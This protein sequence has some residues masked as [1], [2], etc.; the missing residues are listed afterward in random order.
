MAD[1]RK[2]TTQLLAD[3][4]A[5]VKTNMQARELKTLLDAIVV[6]QKA[7][8]YYETITDFTGG[9]TT[10]LDSIPTIGKTA[11]IRIAVTINAFPYNYQL[12]SGTIA[13]Y[14]EAA[15][16]FITP[17]DYNADTNAKVWVCMDNLIPMKV[18]ISADRT[19]LLK[20]PLEILDAL[21]ENNAVF[22][23][24]GTG[25]N[26]FNTAAFAAAADNV[27][28]LYYEE[29]ASNLMEFNASFIEAKA[30]EIHSKAGLGHEIKKNK[31]LYLAYDG[32]ANIADGDGSLEF[33]IYL[34]LIR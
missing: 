28:R 10:D 18:S 2:D 11:G 30:T 16:V 26:I 13:D 12:V 8:M 22:P 25:E 19:Q 33:V 32:E 21:G 20:T 6:G 27:I 31:K 3:I 29:E 34:T 5:I 15:P 9:T 4:L 14:P 1:E 24:F 17:D 23:S 7:P